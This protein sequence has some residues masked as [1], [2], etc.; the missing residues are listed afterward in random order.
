MNAN[1]SMLMYSK[2]IL[3]MTINL[4]VTPERLP[5]T[6]ER[7]SK[8]YNILSIALFYE[9]DGPYCRVFVERKPIVTPPPQLS[10]RRTCSRVDEEKNAGKEVGFRPTAT[11]PPGPRLPSGPGGLLQTTVAQKTVTF[12]ELPPF[13]RTCSGVMAEREAGK[14]VGFL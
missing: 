9:H 14:E 10:F 13:G 12:A 2:R 4:T 1:Y 5:S 7:L 3:R 8:K 11:A 6:L